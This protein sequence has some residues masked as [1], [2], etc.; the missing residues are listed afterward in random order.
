MTD[1]SARPRPLTKAEAAAALRCS[2][3]TVQR[4]VAEG[5]LA[6]IRDSANRLLFLPEFIEAYWD[7]HTKPAAPAAR[8]QTRNPKYA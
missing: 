8:K 5:Q 4:R 2:T 3:R 1:N 6:S 7:R